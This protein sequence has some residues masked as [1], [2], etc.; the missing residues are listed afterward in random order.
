M[1]DAAVADRY[2][3]AIF[4]LGVE[5]GQLERLSEQIKSMAAAYSASPDLQATLD[6]PLVEEAA[7]EKLLM[8]LSSRLGL[9]ELAVNAV[10]LLGRRQ[11]LSALPAIALR[12]SSLAD[13]K[14][15]VVRAEV[16]S[17][18]PLSEAVY[19]QLAKKLEAATK[20]KVVLERKQDPSLIAGIV[21]R[22]GDN[23][24]DGS[25]KGRLSDLERQLLS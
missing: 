9:D 22:I 25:L 21:T 5:T 24:I 3:R 12:L 16:V 2:A 7:R 19:D 23:T 8:G 14:A 1:S 10:K 11:R 4:E 6:N 18:T 13:E 15:G 17:A 20:R